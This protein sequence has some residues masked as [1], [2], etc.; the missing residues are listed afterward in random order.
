MEESPKKN[1]SRYGRNPKA[2]PKKYVHGFTLNENEN[3]Q[4]LSLVKASGA[5]NKSQYITSVLLG[6]KIKTVSIDMAAME[7]YIRLTTFYNQFSVIAISYKEATDTLNL[8]FSRDKARI[9]VSKLETL[10]IRLSEICYEVKKLTEQFESNYLK[11]IK[12]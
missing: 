8:K 11:E 9:V 7:Y 1:A 3:T 2:N 6:K 5:K 12:K 10:T 4:F